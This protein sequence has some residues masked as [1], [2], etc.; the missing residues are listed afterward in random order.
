MGAG[1][2][3]V[4]FSRTQPNAEF[5]DMEWI[6]GDINNF[7]DCYKAVQGRGFNAIHNTAAKPSPTDIPGTKENEDFSFFT[8]TMRHC[9]PISI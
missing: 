1:H 7:E 6:N 3:V 8:M 4:L 2:N 9:F 5:K